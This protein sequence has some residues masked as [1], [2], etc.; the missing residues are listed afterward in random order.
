MEHLSFLS[1]ALELL[2]PLPILPSVTGVLGFDP[3]ALLAVGGVL[4]HLACIFRLFFS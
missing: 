1:K 4:A 3:G 2:E